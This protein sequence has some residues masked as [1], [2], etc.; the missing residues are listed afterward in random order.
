MGA[1]T[2]VLIASMIVWAMMPS[3]GGS[4]STAARAQTFRLDIRPDAQK[5]FEKITTEHNAE[6]TKAN[7][8]ELKESTARNNRMK[9]LRQ[10]GIRSANNWV[11]TVDGLSTNND[12]KA[13][14]SVRINGNV[15]VKTRSNAFSD[16]GEDTLI[17]PGT[18]LFDSVAS[19]RK[20][21][22]VRFSGN[23]LTGD[24]LDHLKTGGSTVRG[25]MKDTD[26][27]M[28]FTSVTGLADNPATTAE[29]NL[30]EGPSTDTTVLAT[31]PKGKR[32][33]L[34][35]NVEDGGWGKW[36]TNVL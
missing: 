31:I 22:N 26:F 4:S 20:G 18:P 10:A 27:L 32:V 16:I 14:L 29:V 28:R 33:K 17:P 9:V 35:G 5:N 2:F 13:V 15:S 11:G 34:L 25:A 7:G 36:Q 21:Q 30:R 23:F 6:F 8:N 3:S 19:L 1:V 24:D 12:G